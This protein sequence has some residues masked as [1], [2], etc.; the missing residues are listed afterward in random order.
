MH[1]SLNSKGMMT[2][3]LRPP[4][5]IYNN[6]LTFVTY[7]GVWWAFRIMY[8]IPPLQQKACILKNNLIMSVVWVGETLYTNIFMILWFN[9]GL[10][11]DL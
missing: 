10:F 11:L 3:Q 6:K 7:Y 1:S 8:N 4:K 9:I 2:M 5:A